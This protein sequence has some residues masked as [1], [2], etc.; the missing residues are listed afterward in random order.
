MRGL[1]GYDGYD[2]N[3]GS[4]AKKVFKSPATAVHCGYELKR[5]ALLLC[6]QALRKKDM[7]AKEDVDL[8]RQLYEAEWHNRVV[9]PAL[10]HLPVRKHN[11]PSYCH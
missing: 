10:N 8:F 6:S 2:E 9:A 1:Y 4:T 3:D 7:T 5:A 11:F